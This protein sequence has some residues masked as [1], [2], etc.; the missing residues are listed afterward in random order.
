MTSNEYF[1]EHIINGET[2][3]EKEEKSFYTKKNF[4]SS[5]D[6]S[7][8]AY[9]V[10][11]TPFEINELYFLDKPI[12][13]NFNSSNLIKNDD[14]KLIIFKTESDPF[15]KLLNKKTKKEVCFWANSNLKEEKK[16]KHFKKP[17]NSHKKK[18][19]TAEDDDNILRKIQVMFLSFIISFTNDIV[20]SLTDD[21]TIRLFKDLD[22]QIKKKVSHQSVESLKSKK[23]EDIIKFKITPKIKQEKNFNEQIYKSILE[24]CPIIQ[25]FFNKSYLSL[26][27]EYYENQN[28]IFRFNEKVIPLSYKTKQKTFDKLID[29]NNKFKEKI[30]YV[31]VNYILNSYKRLKKPNF[32]ISS[33][34]T[35]NQNK[36]IE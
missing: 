12:K 6:Y 23:I 33:C 36:K 5:N 9:D 35:S 31:S 16:S 11:I 10:T 28:N 14:K 7:L 24:R 25:E 26:F 17:K 8:E 19:H 3:S 20:L 30:K 15:K 13:I 2:N 1:N 34:K 32:K 18:P 29:K 22:Y 21:K 4:D 27:K